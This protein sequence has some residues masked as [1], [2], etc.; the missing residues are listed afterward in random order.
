MTLA[1]RL[2]IENG[3][4]FLLSTLFLVGGGWSWRNAQPYELPK[5]LPAW[6]QVWFGVVQF[7]GSVPPLIAM[8]CG[9]WQGIPL[10]KQVLLAYFVLLA[11]QVMIEVLTLRQ[12]QSIAW[13]M[14][15]YLYVPYRLW[16]L[17]EG[18]TLTT[19]Q[20]SESWLALFFISEM[21]VWGS[22][23]LLDL[24]QLPRLLQWPG[25]TEA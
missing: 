8:I 21:V 15:P 6:F 3:T 10:L 1:Q 16:Q 2:L 23:Y 5:P 18:L 20:S 24:A 12:F 14:V 25:T 22:N 9:F 19:A 11:L 4:F 17:W 7:W 13:V